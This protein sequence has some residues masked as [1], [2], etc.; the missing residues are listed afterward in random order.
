[1]CNFYPVR[2]RVCVGLGIEVK[3]AM[4]ATQQG[5]TS[6]TSNPAQTLGAWIFHLDVEILVSPV[7]QGPL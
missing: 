5:S 2:P 7:P 6:S 4:N 3:L 1:M